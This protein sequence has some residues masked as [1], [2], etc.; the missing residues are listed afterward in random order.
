[1]FLLQSDIKVSDLHAVLSGVTRLVSPG[2]AT[3]SVTTIF[4]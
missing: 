1:M 4:S 2:A 3:D